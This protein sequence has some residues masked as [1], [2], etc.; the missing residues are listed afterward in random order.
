MRTKRLPTIG[1]SVATTRRQ[2][3]WGWGG[4]GY[5]SYTLSC[6]EKDTCGNITFP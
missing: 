1:D 4:V 6:G 2:Y 3:W 5:R